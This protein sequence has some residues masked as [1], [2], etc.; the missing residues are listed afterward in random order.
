MH[1]VSHWCG[2]ILILGEEIPSLG[3]KS[4]PPPGQRSCHTIETAP[5][6]DQ[7]VTQ[8]VK[9]C[10]GEEKRTE[11]SNLTVNKQICRQAWTTAFYGCRVIWSER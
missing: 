3:E 11:G 7:K 1:F 5:Q 8:E 9:A 6:W 4:P 2:E 10:S